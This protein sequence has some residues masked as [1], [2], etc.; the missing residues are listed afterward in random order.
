[1]DRLD[2]LQGD[3]RD[4]LGNWV[5]DMAEV[6]KDGV[7]RG[8]KLSAEGYEHVVQGFDN[9]KKCV[10]DGRSRLERLIKTA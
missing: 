9:M 2:D 8:R 10:D 5:D 1:V 3:I 4:K 7:D 6:A